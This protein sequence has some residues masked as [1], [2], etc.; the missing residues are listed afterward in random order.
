M[1]KSLVNNFGLKMISIVL[2]FL[3]WLIVVQDNDP[4]KVK[5][6]T[7]IQVEVENQESLEKL[8][9]VYEVL[10]NTDTVTVYATGRNSVIKELDNSD[11]R[12]SADLENLNDMG[13]VQYVVTCKNSSIKK[14][15]IKVEP[16]SLKVRIEPKVEKS[17]AVKAVTTGNP[18]TGYVIGNATVNQGDSI[19]VAGPQSLINIISRVVVLVDVNGLNESKILKGTLKIID[20]NDEEFAETKMKSMT[21]KTSGGVPITELGSVEVTADLWRIKPDIKL[22]VNVVGM[23]AVG[24]KKTNITITPETISLAGTESALEELNGRLQLNEDVSVEGATSDVTK[25]IELQD[26]LAE[27]H[28]LKL[29]ETATDTVTVTVGIEKAGTKTEYLPVNRLNT[30]NVPADLKM[31][32]TP[33]DKIPIIITTTT[34]DLNDFDAEDI[35]AT[36]DLSSY[37]TTGTYT[38]KLDVELPEGFVLASDV[39]I[40]VNL[41]KKEETAI[42]EKSTVEE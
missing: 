30:K 32:L 21:C 38:V 18:K 10:N 6:F 11:F 14:E 16:S 5:P 41:E 7:N 23:P 8:G 20:K 39:T 12:V 29:A 26:M 15:N 17:F 19:I 35:K 33:S 9:K 24:Y 1:K 13:T 4:E 42:T 40:V 27:Q 22:D 3:I 36:L 31:T 34:G 2:A 25:K 37:K 28:D